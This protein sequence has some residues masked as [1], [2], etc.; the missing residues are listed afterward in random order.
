MKKIVSVFLLFAI[1]ISLCACGSSIGAKTPTP[2][3]KL[4]GHPDASETVKL[5]GQP[6]YTA[7]DHLSYS[8]IE[9]MGFKNTNL[10]IWYDSYGFFKY[11]FWQVNDSSYTNDDLEKAVNS[12]IK[13]LNANFGEYTRE[14]GIY[15]WYDTVGNSYA[16]ATKPPTTLNLFYNNI[17]AAKK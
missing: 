12:V 7:P 13:K 11:A 15:I 2:F 5:L 8:G 4:S 10:Y 17:S 14:D 9:A 6:G 1:V 3:D 16:L